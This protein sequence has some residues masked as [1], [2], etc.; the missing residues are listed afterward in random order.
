MAAPVDSA[1][2]EDR[3]NSFAELCRRAGIR[4]THQ[5]MEVF[6][7]VAG[8]EE[9]PDVESI[10]RRVRR[11]VPAISL[12]TV[13]RTLR[14]FEE[15]GLVSRV[16]YPGD[17]A[18]FDGN[19]DHHHHFI[20]TGCGLVRDFYSDELDAFRPPGAAKALGKV[21]TVHVELRGL[22]RECQRK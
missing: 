22:C 19:T 20:C 4:A 16:S 11:R 14:L 1:V 12:D 13:Y 5:R 15:R 8:T 3:M 21:D 2:L 6:R 18:R 17:R 10:H 9:H 7:D